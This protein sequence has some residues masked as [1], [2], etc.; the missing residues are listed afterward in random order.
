[1]RA[2]DVDVKD[3]EEKSIM[4]YVAQFLQYSNDMPAPD[5]H[6]QVGNLYCRTD[7]ITFSQIHISPSWKFK[8]K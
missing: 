4:T 5:D 1:M 3:P 8:F 6:L 7:S 2:S